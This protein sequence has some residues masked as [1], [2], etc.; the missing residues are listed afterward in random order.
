MSALCLLIIIILKHGTQLHTNFIR[1]FQG[2]KTYLLSEIVGGV[3]EM[4]S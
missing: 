3:K 4:Y 2:M 1:Y